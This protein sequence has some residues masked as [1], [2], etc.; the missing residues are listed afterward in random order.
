[1]IIHNA[2][3][4]VYP[5]GRSA[6]QGW[7]LLGLWLA[8][9]QVFVLWIYASR[10]QDTTALVLAA[11]ILAA[12]FASW[13]GWKNAP[14]GLLAWDGQQWRWESTGYKAGIAEQELTVIADFQRILLLRI[15]NQAKASL[16]LWAEQ[17]VF[18]DRWMDLRRA[19]YSPHRFSGPAAAQDLT[20]PE[21]ALSSAVGEQAVL[22]KKA[23][24]RP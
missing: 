9:L 2:P 20:S 14:V 13:R 4:V 10:H 16:W 23:A 15:Q 18:P 12:G 21:P 8:G 3:P 24:A 7:L 1:M 5:L 6:F 17:K 11:S 19:V 22:P